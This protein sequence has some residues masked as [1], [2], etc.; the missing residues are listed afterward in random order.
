MLFRSYIHLG[1]SQY[2]N[3]LFLDDVEISPSE[4]TKFLGIFIDNKLSFNSHVNSLVS[5]C[6]ARLFLMRKLKTFGL[7]NDGL[8]TFYVSNIRSVMSYAAPAWYT[9]LSNTNKQ[10]LERIQRSATRIITPD[11]DYDERLTILQLPYL[12]DFLFDLAHSHFLKIMDNQRHPLFSRLSFNTGSRTSSRAN[13]RFRPKRCRTNKRS[14][15][16]FIYFMTYHDN[17]F[18]Y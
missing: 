15:S 11:I 7:N 16:F 2:D 14:N 1:K 8:K 17:H 12:N 10:R 18:V 3:D 6:N 5:K 9:L 13:F 4:C